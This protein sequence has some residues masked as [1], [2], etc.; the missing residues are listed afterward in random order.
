MYRTTEAIATQFHDFFST[1]SRTEAEMVKHS[2]SYSKDCEIAKN[3][4]LLG[5]VY[6]IALFQP[7]VMKLKWAIHNMVSSGVK[8]RLRRFKDNFN[9]VA[10]ATFAQ[11]LWSTYLRVIFKRSKLIFLSVEV[12]PFS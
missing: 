5:N 3:S 2:S 9:F 8:I 12:C 10:F 4:I 7:H 6:S 11:T 1:G